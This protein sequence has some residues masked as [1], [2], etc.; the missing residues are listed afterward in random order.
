MKM[1]KRHWCWCLIQR[2]QHNLSILQTSTERL[3]NRALSHIWQVKSCL[4]DTFYTRPYLVQWDH[5][6]TISSES[7]LHSNALTTVS[8]PISV[9]SCLR[10]KLSVSGYACL[11]SDAV[12]ILYNKQVTPHCDRDWSLSAHIF[13][14]RLVLYAFSFRRTEAI[15]ASV[16]CK[17]PTGSGQQRL[18]CPCTKRG[19]QIAPE[20]CFRSK[21]LLHPYK[22]WH[23]INYFQY[24]SKEESRPLVFR[25]QFLL[26]WS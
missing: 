25:R 12:L 3:S 23:H 17:D 5:T 14:E 11:H 7:A 10:E 8:S 22:I 26:F 15:A 4:D 6:A 1:S 18:P 2:T 24:K 20:Q 13:P 19:V 21:A 16:T 9:D